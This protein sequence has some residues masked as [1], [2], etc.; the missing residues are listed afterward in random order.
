VT[1][2]FEELYKVVFNEDREILEAIQR[3]EDEEPDIKPM[4]IASD[5]GLARLRRMVEKQ[6]NEERAG[7]G[8]VPAGAETR[9]AASPSPA[10]A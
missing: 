7:A 1:R 5:S 6:L 2:E 3:L 10:P 8:P 4:R 9:P